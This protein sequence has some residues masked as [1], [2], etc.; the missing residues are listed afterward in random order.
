LDS[1]LGDLTTLLETISRTALA[2]CI[3][4]PVKLEDEFLETRTTEF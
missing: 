4:E 2:T 3:F 1:P